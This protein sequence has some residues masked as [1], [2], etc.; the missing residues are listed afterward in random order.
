MADGSVLVATGKNSSGAALT[1]A[2]SII[3]LVRTA[4]LAVSAD[5]VGD[6]K[7]N[8]KGT[9]MERRVARVLHGI[10]GT[11]LETLE[12]SGFLSAACCALGNVYERVL[13]VRRH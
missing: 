2:C 5:M 3:N 11:N 13:S 12:I 8:S 1:S 4:F 10:F 6:N 9:Q 7:L